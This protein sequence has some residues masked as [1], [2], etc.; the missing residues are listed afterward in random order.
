MKRTKKTDLMCKITAIILAAGESRRMK[1]PKMLLPFQGKTIIEKVIETVISSKVRDVIVV[2]GAVKEKMIGLI[3]KYPVTICHNENYTEGMISSVKCGIRYLAPGTDAVIVF[4]GDQPMIPSEVID[5]V[6]DS[7]RNTKKGLVLPVFEGKRGHPLLIS[8]SFL[9]E[10]ENIG[11]ETGLRQLLIK[12]PKDIFEVES[13]NS[14][15][16]KDID[17]EEDY[18]QEITQNH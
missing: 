8:S 17:T 13:K 18:H 16:L 6:I 10:I 12:F 1:S 9:T 11:N 14:A 15:I 7:F 5:K 4:L 2:L 3:E